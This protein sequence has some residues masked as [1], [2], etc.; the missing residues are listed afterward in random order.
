MGLLDLFRSKK[1]RLEDQVKDWISSMKSEQRMLERE[2]RAIEREE[3][4]VKTDLRNSIQNNRPSVVKILAKELVRSKRAKEQLY[5]TKANLNSITLQLQNQLGMYRISKQI[6]IT[7]EIIGK[8][9]QLMNVETISKDIKN[10]S[11]EM[12]HAGLIQDTLQKEFDRIDE[13]EGIEEVAEEE[14]E[15][16]IDE[17]VTEIDK[18]SK[19]IDETFGRE[20][21]KEGK[22]V[23]MK[24]T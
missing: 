12:E 15:K 22:Q 10:I 3:S 14:I 16:V 6:N 9:N 8:M 7:N 20:R 1:K 2:I 21:F 17:I 4:K 19:Q 13:K 23:P 18:K 5:L 24:M 11:I